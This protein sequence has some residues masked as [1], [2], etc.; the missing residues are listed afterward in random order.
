M[1]YLL[2]EEDVVELKEVFSLLAEHAAGPHAVMPGETPTNTSQTSAAIPP[3]ERW[4]PPPPPAAQQS[5]I[6][7][8]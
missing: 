4:V 5:L 3:A 7:K 1:W 8:K 2:S 6:H